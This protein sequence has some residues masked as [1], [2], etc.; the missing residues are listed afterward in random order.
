MRASIINA[1]FVNGPVP[2]AAMACDRARAMRTAGHC[3]TTPVSCH[4]QLFVCAVNLFFSS[5]GW[6]RRQ[7]AATLSGDQTITAPRIWPSFRCLDTRY[8]HERMG[9]KKSIELQAAFQP[10]KQLHRLSKT[11]VECGN[12]NARET[13]N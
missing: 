13:F 6:M 9:E 10:G 3:S 8:E 4:A 11:D 7:G 12:F 1:S 2:V 5:D